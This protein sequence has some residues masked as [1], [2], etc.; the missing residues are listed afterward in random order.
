MF[1][2]ARKA[3]GRATA[4][5]RTPRLLSVAT[6]GV[7]SM[8]SAF[9]LVPSAAANP[10]AGTG[11]IAAPPTAQPASAEAGNPPNLT[12]PAPHGSWVVTPSAP[13]APA[14]TADPDN[15]NYAPPDSTVAPPESLTD[16]TG[17]GPLTPSALNQ[18]MSPDGR[19]V[20]N[21]ITNVT[22]GV[23][24][25]LPS[26]D[27]LD[28]AIDQMLDR[29]Q[30]LVPQHM[31]PLPQQDDEV[32]FEDG[33][34][35]IVAADQY[36]DAS[37][38]DPFGED[39]TAPSDSVDVDG[40]MD[41]N[42]ADDADADVSDTDVSDSGTDS[43]DTDSSDGDSGFGGDSGTADSGADSTTGAD[44][45]SDGGL[46]GNT[47]GDSSGDSGGDSGSSSSGDG[48]F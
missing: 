25:A 18:Y 30:Q 2:P 31:D 17:S 27:D 21:I 19:D 44:S 15:T 11:S 42:S 28:N 14:F 6:I 41:A 37:T 39:A 43:G 24:P 22:P 46:G 7:V 9:G 12:G 10:L 8:G 38:V 1:I 34:P 13:T 16:P 5:A 3:R 20:Y 47:G 40:T 45:G 48:G 4:C 33:F 23:V 36:A 32:G 26:D 35:D 29:R